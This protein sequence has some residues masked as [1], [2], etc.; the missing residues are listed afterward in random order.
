MPVNAK[1]KNIY[2]GTKE[3][4]LTVNLQ[5]VQPLLA[6]CFLSALNIQEEGTFKKST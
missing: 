4:Y 2:K 1:K 3:K 5:K 6:S